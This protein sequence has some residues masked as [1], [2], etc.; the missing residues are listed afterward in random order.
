MS[1]AHEAYYAS[2]EAH[3][4]RDE[5]FFEALYGAAGP[6]CAEIYKL[7]CDSF[8]ELDILN[9]VEFETGLRPY[10]SA[11]A[12]A[13]NSNQDPLF[14][15]YTHSGRPYLYMGKILP[16]IKRMELSKK[17]RPFI[18]PGNSSDE[19][20]MPLLFAN[21]L[22][23]LMQRDQ[24]FTRVFGPIEQEQPSRNN[25]FRPFSAE[26]TDSNA[27]YITTFLVGSSSFGLEFGLMK[28]AFLPHEW[29]LWVANK[30]PPEPPGVC[31]I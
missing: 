11:H 30:Q 18:D 21:E 29:R 26:D 4:E 23:R 15:G 5:R 27:N 12:K 19:K 8:P 14:D 9:E 3:P 6:R 17:L 13:R 31:T 25:D 24:N 2:N 28:P 1:S 16:S 7:A 20:F 10:N 22:A